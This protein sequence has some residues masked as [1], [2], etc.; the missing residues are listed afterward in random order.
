[1]RET[2]TSDPKQV[3]HEW[4]WVGLL[5]FLGLALRLAISPSYGYGGFEGDMIDY[6]QGT[7]RVLTLGIHELY[8]LNQYNSLAVTGGKWN[9]GF[10]A[11]YPPVNYYIWMVF[12]APYRWLDR[13]DFDLW[14]STLNFYEIAR[15]DL[16]ERLARTRVFTMLIKLPSILAELGMALLAYVVTRR[17]RG[18][19]VALLAAGVIAFNPALIVDS[20]HWGAP[21]AVH[22]LFIVLALLLLLRGRAVLPGVFLALAVLAKP[23]VVVFVPIVLLIA[24]KQV[25][26]RGLL[27]G[28]LAG[29]ATALL[30]VAPFILHGT[31]GQFVEG[32]LQTVGEEPV[33]SANANN[34]WWLITN[35]QAYGMV[36]TVRIFG[37][38]TIRHLSLLFLAIAYLYAVL[39]WHKRGATEFAVAAFVGFAFF[40][41]PTEIHENHI[42][43]ALPLLAFALPYDR[44]LLRILGVISVTMFVNML[45]FDPGWLTKGGIVVYGVTL[46][47]LAMAALNTL[48]FGGLAWVLY[49]PQRAA[50]VEMEM[51]EIEIERKR[52]GTRLLHVKSCVREQAQSLCLYLQHYFRHYLALLLATAALV[53]LA[54][55]VPSAPVTV[56]L[57]RQGDQRLIRGFYFREQDAVHGTFRWTGGRGEITFPGVGGGPVRLLVR[58][59]G[60][61]PAGPAH[62]TLRA[63]GRP[64]ARFDA[65]GD[66]SAYSFDLPRG[67]A[68]PWGDLVITLDSDTFV[69][70]PDPRSLGLLVDEVR[71]EPGTPWAPVLPPLSQIVLLG[72][73]VELLFLWLLWWGLATRL[74][75]VGGLF[76]ALIGA[77]GYAF[78]RPWLTLNIWPAVVGF[79]SLILLAAVLAGLLRL[80]TRWLTST[81]LTALRTRQLVLILLFALALRLPFMATTGYDADVRMY[82]TWSWKATALGIHT[83]YEPSAGVTS[84][85][86]PGILYPFKAIGWTYQHLFDAEFPFP[87]QT[88]MDHRFLLRFPAVLSDLLI[89]VFVYAVARRRLN[90]WPAALVLAS[91]VFNPAI[92]F[93]SAY[94]GQLDA[95]HSLLVVAAVVIIGEGF[96]GWGWLVMGLAM[97][98]KPQTYVVAPLLVLITA[99]RFGWWGLVRGGLASVV[100]ALLIALPFLRYG[101]FQS[102]A[103]Y[104]VSITQVHPVVGANAD[105][106][107]WWM[108]W[109]RAARVFDTTPVPALATLGLSLSY[110]TTGIILVLGVLLFVWYAAWRRPHPPALYEWAA[111]SALVFF[112]LSTEMHENYM[113]LAL[114][115]LALV[116]YT[117]RRLT[118]LYALLSATFVANMALH[119]PAIVAWLVPQNPDIFFGKE[120]FWP[121][122]M[123]SILNTLAL[124]WWL[125]LLRSPERRAILKK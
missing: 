102:F 64:L 58:L 87:E 77:A 57:G 7:H 111:L 119:Y 34:L 15:T 121:R 103:R 109:G 117:D 104:M 26:W 71:L 79:G 14:D 9:G 61:R 97:L 90:H 4:F 8:S 62:V 17:K 31:F 23:Q 76:G 30:V 67:A 84:D 3:S 59:S 27:R 18:F 99:R 5:L 88:R 1:V 13:A 11:D 45:A 65:G 44:R 66:L 19:R 78:A 107:W 10:F 118:I 40:M 52:A 49:T 96:P 50:P 75:M 32:V 46:T 20:S 60:L 92:I 81:T 82:E 72:I 108:T 94:Y 100:G 122:L 69:P 22:T 89:G 73:C 56:D 63:N 106:F 54:Y 37:P 42:Y 38:F 6:K 125:W 25:G 98:T 86:H 70:G 110:R 91:F 115:L 12:V 101:T 83:L 2:G 48:A 124:V 95:V 113:Y 74:A 93:D 47:G 21:D 123:T 105:N 51:K 29:A 35:G 68:G 16:W 112:V 41:L 114:P 116:Y 33:L 85:N 120:L 24:W 43:P 28:A 53:T 36:D 39:S 55:Q 80:L